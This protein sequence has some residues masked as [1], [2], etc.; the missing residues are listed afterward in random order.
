MGIKLCDFDFHV[1]YRGFV[2]CS[3]IREEISQSLIFSD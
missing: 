2:G 1:I 3:L